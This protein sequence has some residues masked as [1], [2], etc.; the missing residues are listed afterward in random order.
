[1]AC[2]LPPEP[3]D[4]ALLT[5]IDGEADSHVV[6]HLEQCPHCRERA[7]R[8]ARFQDRLSTQLSP[9]ECPP[10]IKL[11]EYHLGML[12]RAQAADVGRHL[13]KCPDCAREI[14]QLQDFLERL[15]PEPATK[16]RDEVE[17]LFRDKVEVLVAQLV[18]R[19]SGSTP[20]GLPVRMAAGMSLRGEEQQ[21]PHLYR[22]DDVEVAVEVQDDAE[23]WGHK[24][25]LG[26][27]TGRDTHAWMAQLWQAEQCVATAPVD[28][29]G[30]FIMPGLAL[31]GSYELTLSAPEVRVHIR[32]LTI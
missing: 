5:F 19:W 1:M 10:S 20:S 7:N 17:V 14:A 18:P 30:N 4:R 24:V 27:I 28:D 15:N 13:K 3:N 11:G 31:Q 8:L 2:V 29:S 25:V 6:A 22:V 32:D 23:R 21:G 9:F 16:F 26:L 12:P